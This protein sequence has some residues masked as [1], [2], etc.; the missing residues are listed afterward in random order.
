[1]SSGGDDIE[2]KDCQNDIGA[3]LADY[4]DTYAQPST[5]HVSDALSST[6]TTSTSD[7]DQTS[8]PSPP[9][10]PKRAK[11]RTQMQWDIPNYTNLNNGSREMSSISTSPLL[12]RRH[13]YI[14]HHTSYPEGQNIVDRVTVK[15]FT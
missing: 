5:T 9:V 11:P 1:M 2:V 15:K 4:S 13:R 12:R 14:G 6:T 8:V 3:A 10:F 7:M